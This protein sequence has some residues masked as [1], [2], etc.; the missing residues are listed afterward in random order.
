MSEISTSVSQDSHSNELDH[1]LLIK[2]E[3]LEVSV[4]PMNESHHLVKPSDESE[5]HTY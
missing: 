2:D 5:S 1:T 4:G 3:D